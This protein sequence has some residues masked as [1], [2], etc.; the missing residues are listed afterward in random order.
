MINSFIEGKIREN[1]GFKPTEEQSAAIGQI[2]LFL[3]SE[4]SKEAFLLRGYA[5]TGKT[6]LVGALVKTLDQLKQHVVLMAPTGRAAKVFALY[7]GHPAYTIHRRIY[8][9]KSLTND[10]DFSLNDNLARNTL[11]IV[12]EASMIG[13]D[14]SG[15]VFGSGHLLDDLITFV[16]SGEGCRLLM[17][18]DTA[19]LPP[20]GQEESPALQREVLQMYGL[21][22]Q[23]VQLT[24][25]MRQ[26][27]LSGVLENA[28]VIRRRVADLSMPDEYT[29][30]D[31]LEQPVRLH[32]R[33]DVIAIN[34]SMLI[35][36][37]SDA[38]DQ[39]GDDDTIVICRTNK[40]ANIYNRGIRATILYR[41]EEL[42]TGD[43]IMVVKNNYFWTEQEAAAAAAGNE[44]Y[45]GPTFLA[46]GDMAVVRRIRRER[47][48]Y[49]FRFA[50]VTLD[51]P[52]YDDFELEATVLLDTLTSEAPSLTKKDADRLFNAVMEDYAD[53]TVKAE[54]YKEMRRNPYFNALQIKSA[55][56]VTCHKA[57]GGQWHTVFLDRGW[58][59]PETIGTPE[60]YR[61]LYTAFT[62]AT[63]RV[64]LVNWPAAERDGAI[65]ED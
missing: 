41:E 61:W 8:R 54:R 26:G 59:P 31:A 25:V 47:E 28:T 49:G 12:D 23:V 63:H 21:K 32:C 24:E 42:T 52:D 17:L 55:Y 65:I 6:T 34:G 39:V 10:A 57:Q 62:R 43:R 56:A 37:L 33:K 53:I 45:T 64:Y 5:G 60:Y 7:S 50:D 40:N 1:F 2:A 3:T 22:V 13:D 44:P 19:Q 27:H 38:Y 35:D 9:Q 16:Y 18:G 14:A 51:F 46:N 48:M 11:F 36:T 29:D 15:S 30:F 58:I 4:S 20:V